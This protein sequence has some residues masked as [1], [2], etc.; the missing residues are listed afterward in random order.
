MVD[1]YEQAGV[2][3]HYLPVDENVP[4]PGLRPRQLLHVA[5]RRRHLPA[6]EPQAA[7]GVRRRCCGFY[8]E[9]DI[10]VY[11]MVSAGN[12]EGGDFNIIHHGA[13]LV[14][15]TDHRSERIAAEQVGDW[16]IKEGWENQVR[17]DRLLLRPHRPHGLHAERALRRGVPRH[18]AGRRRR[19]LKGRGIEIVPATF[20][21]TMALGC[22]VV[23]L[24][25]DRVLST[26]DRPG[27]QREDARAG[28]TVYDPDMTMYTWAGGGVHCMCQPLR[29]E[30]A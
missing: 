24:G 12:F 29:R 20:R 14:G 1:A 4:L 9:N 23:A 21:E 27:P 2:T 15:Y 7:R 18:H 19:G 5:L 28:F 3:C 6:R 16:F 8:L 17:A 30:A 13:A 10:P 26:L 22:N 25:K 11:D